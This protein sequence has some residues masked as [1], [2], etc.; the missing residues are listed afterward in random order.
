MVGDFAMEA[1]TRLWA[2]CEGGQKGEYW[3][4]A[5]PEFVEAV[6]DWK[7]EPGKLFEALAHCR[8]IHKHR[9]GI[10]IHEWASYNWRRV[11]NWHNGKKSPGRPKKTQQAHS[12]TPTTPTE[13]QHENGST[14]G[15]GRMNDMNDMNELNETKEERERGAGSLEASKLQWGILNQRIKELTSRLHHLDPDE[16]EELRKLR[17]EQK[18]IEEKQKA[19]NFT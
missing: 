8:W 4:G 9:G 15:E 3:K 10:R 7:G 11:S 13:T 12:V 2:H 5:T 17:A 6:C 1:L 19:G 14:T 18:A 16:R